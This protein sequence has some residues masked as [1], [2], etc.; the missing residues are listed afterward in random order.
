MQG[1]QATSITA[2]LVAGAVSTILLWILGYYAP[3]LMATAPPTIEQAIGI[4]ITAAIC[5]YLPAWGAP[6]AHEPNAKAAQPRP[7][8]LLEDEG[9]ERP[10][11]PR[12]P[13]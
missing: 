13:L 7:L 4:L 8:P 1:G 3:G 11:G 10:L 5:Y 2:V 9:D 6:A 12:G